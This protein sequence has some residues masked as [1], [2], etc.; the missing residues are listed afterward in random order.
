[1]IFRKKW[2]YRPLFLGIYFFSW[3]LN[4]MK[5]SSF[6]NSED[7]RPLYLQDASFAPTHITDLHDKLNHAYRHYE[8]R[9]SRYRAE[10]C[11]Y[12]LWEITRF[13]ELHKDNSYQEVI[14]I[15]SDE[16]KQDKHVKDK[17]VQYWILHTPTAMD[18]YS[19]K[20]Y[21]LARYL[22]RKW[23]YDTTS[24][25]RQAEHAL[26]RQ[27]YLNKITDKDQRIRRELCQQV[28]NYAKA[29]REKNIKNSGHEKK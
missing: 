3:Q 13:Q 23:I 1:M 5:A 20:E 14:R 11:A 8:K 10:E 28:L 16:I 27:R 9:T 6:C 12:I 24:P 25:E 2:R 21:V 18:E 19:K 26:Y 22:R 17:A 4:E 15:I 7:T 29:Q